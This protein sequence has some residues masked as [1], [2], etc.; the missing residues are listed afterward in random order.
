MK[1]LCIQC[2]KNPIYIK[3]RKLCRKC[4]SK[5]WVGQVSASDKK[6]ISPFEA[7]KTKQ[8]SEVEFIRNFFEHKNWYYHPANFQLKG[9]KYQPDFYD[10]ERNVF[11]EVSGTP[12]AFHSNKRKYIQF[13]K[14][15][16]KIKF[17][18]R[19]STGEL[20]ND[21]SYRLPEKR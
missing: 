4:Y 16:P 17:E 3:K 19:Y 15:Y 6:R 11:I 7:K 21:M 9:T 10:G 20:L 2:R 1:N 13:I 5:F 14:E 12:S 8:S 18:I